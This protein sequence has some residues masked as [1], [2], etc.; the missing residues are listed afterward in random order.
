MQPPR[1]RRRAPAHRRALQNGRCRSSR[2]HGAK[3]LGDHAGLI[4]P[5]L[6]TRQRRF[7]DAPLVGLELGHMGIAV[8]GDAVRREL[9]DDLAC[10]AQRSRRF[11]A[12]IRRSG[13]NSD[14]RYQRRGAASPPTRRPAS[15]A[16]ADRRLNQRIDVLHA[17]TRSGNAQLLQAH[18][19]RWRHVS[20]I[21]FDRVLVVSSKTKCRRRTSTTDASPSV[22]RM[23][24]VPPPQCS[25]ETR[26][27]PDAVSPTSAISR[28]R[29]SRYPPITSSRNAFL[30]LQ[31]Q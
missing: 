15:A 8:A 28:S 25:R 16:A 14:C 12:A 1:C 20:R 19:Q 21:E 13:R 5:F 4:D 23:L 22:P 30:V 26:N 6:D 24:G 2:I 3:F 17:E 29:A 18:R 10:L 31:P 11:A 27:G 9:R 7:V